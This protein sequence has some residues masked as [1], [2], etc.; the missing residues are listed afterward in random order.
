MFTVREALNMEVFKDC[1]LLTGEA[2]LANHVKNINIL[3]I[4]DELSHVEKGEFLITTAFDLSLQTE[5][6]Q[7][8]MIEV[9]A[10]RKIAAL[11]IQTGI[12]LAEVPASLLKEAGNAN[13]PVIELPADMSFKDIIRFL[14]VK[15]L[16]KE[17]TNLDF[18]QKV[19]RQL[20]EAYMAKGMP[21]MISVLSQVIQRPVYLYNALLQQLEGDSSPQ[22][23]EK[24]LSLLAYLHK[25]NHSGG[26]KEGEVVEIGGYAGLP[27]QV[28]MPI[29]VN[30][31]TY[32][33]LAAHGTNFS[34]MELISLKQAASICLLE[35]VK[36]NNALKSK[37]REIKEL[38][39]KLL[40]GEHPEEFNKVLEALNL[41]VDSPYAVLVVAL[42][43]NTDNLQ[44]HGQ[45][46]SA[47]MERATQ[48]ILQLLQ[49]N[50]IPSLTSLNDSGQ[51]ISFLQVKEMAGK[52]HDKTCEWLLGQLQ[53][54]YPNTP[55]IVGVGNCCSSLNNICS[56]YDE[57][58]M[59]L[60]AA[61]MGLVK[62]K[63][64][65][66]AYSDLGY[67]K[68][69]MEID[70]SNALLSFY[71]ETIAPLI[72][73]DRKYDAELVTTLR[74]YMKHLNINKAA[75]ELFVHRHTLKYRLNK[76]KILTGFDIKKPENIFLLFMG[77]KL[78]EYLR[79]VDAL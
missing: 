68:L 4:L 11:A 61:R 49:S 15:L 58:V 38:M 33:Y 75:E 20:M 74:A 19:N 3:E 36:K 67:L 14:L 12:Y 23:D 10:D 50:N 51:L 55:F 26:G 60:K 29:R 66:C 32:G 8:S 9:F 1:R 34:N 73:Y 42:P 71:Q 46:T 21:W 62:G 30:I 41:P 70:N 18:R 65:I 53:Q 77:L 13:L 39:Q 16:E 37:S 5:E 57:A 63:N 22:V 7:V 78:W 48:R 54:I 40:E 52:P 56:S 28:L 31:E 25:G 24:E 45:V 2:G 44:G 69:F 59:A 17:S 72:D 79:T 27:D 64:G 6:Q 35:L 47:G 76:V 43:D